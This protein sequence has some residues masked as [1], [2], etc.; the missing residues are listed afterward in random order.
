MTSGRQSVGE[1]DFVGFKA[2]GV[3]SKNRGKLALGDLQLVSL[4][5]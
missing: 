3:E 5:A 1:G 4:T 2:V